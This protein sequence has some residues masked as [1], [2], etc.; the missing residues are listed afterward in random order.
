MGGD[1]APPVLMGCPRC[2]ASS[3]AFREYCQQVLRNAKAMAQALLQRGYTLVSGNAV[4]GTGGASCGRGRV[5]P[6]GLGAAMGCAGGLG[7]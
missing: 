5:A 3:P 2:Q 7:G 4:L 6:L 1:L